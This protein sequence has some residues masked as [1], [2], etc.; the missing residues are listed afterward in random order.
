[1]AT[2]D[3][4]MPQLGFDMEEGTIQRWLKQEGD[5]VER[6]EALAEV[7]TEKV[8]LQVES[9]STGTLTKIIKG[10]GETVPVGEKIGEIDEE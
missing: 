6:G 10:E 4:I 7:E 9:Y 3:V 8:T 1:M 5:H 2:T